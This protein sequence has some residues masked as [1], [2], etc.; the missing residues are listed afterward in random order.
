MSDHVHIDSLP[1]HRIPG[2]QK[3][4]RD[5]IQIRIVRP[6]QQ[7]PRANP[8]ELDRIVREP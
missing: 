7:I 2:L 6:P 1:R 8:I 3:R 4:P 5:T